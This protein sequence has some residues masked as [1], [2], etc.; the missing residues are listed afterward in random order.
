MEVSHPQ[1]ISFIFRI[2]P[3]KKT[4]KCGNT[5]CNFE[6]E[7]NEVDFWTRRKLNKTSFF[8]LCIICSDAYKNNQYCDYCKQVYFLEAADGREWV[9]CDKCLKWNHIDCEKE[10]NPE[11]GDLIQTEGF[12]YYCPTCSK[13]NNKKPSTAKSTATAHANS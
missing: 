12:K 6:S 1:S 7:G 8:W 2:D 13:S 11:D 10:A 4:K 5:I 3:K 9:E